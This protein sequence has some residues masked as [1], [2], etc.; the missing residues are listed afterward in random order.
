MR[1]WSSVASCHP[2]SKGGA[3][4]V[5]I[6]QDEDVRFRV[7]T[8]ADFPALGELR[9]EWRAAEDP[10][11]QAVEERS[12]FIDRFAAFASDAIT[13][14]RWTAWV[15]EDEGLLVANIWI[16]R[17]PKV[18]SPGR[19][20]RDFGYMTNVYT[21]PDMRNL[22]VGSELLRAVTVWAHEM[23]LEMVVVWPSELSVAWYQRHGFE[24][25]TEM[26]E[27]EV[28]GYEG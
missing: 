20:T 6:G 25:S 17:I 9:W 3:E 18:P 16:Q 10:N 7:A 13:N 24:P 12:A 15:A 5:Q 19:S 14:G 8:T 4:Y 11:R 21:R 26:H 1:Y 2:A 22:G 27:L 28:S 23:D